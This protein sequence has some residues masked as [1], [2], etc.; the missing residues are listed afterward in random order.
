MVT[1]AYRGTQL[2][3]FERLLSDEEFFDAERKRLSCRG[4]EALWQA[5]F[6]AN[7]WIFGHGLFYVFATKF[8]EER[9]EQVVAGSHIAARGKRT[10]ALLRT[11]GLVSS[12]CFVEIKTH[13]TKQRL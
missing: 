8:D 10:D 9:L 4:D 11:Q 2:Q 5:F 13:R 1:I 3:R 7:T 6:E 12:L